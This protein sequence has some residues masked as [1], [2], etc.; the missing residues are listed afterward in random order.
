MQAQENTS[1]DQLDICSLW[2]KDTGY[3]LLDHSLDVARVTEMVC[4]SL[5]FPPAEQKTI[6]RTAKQLAALHDVGK[7]ASGFQ[8]VL[9]GKFK[10]WHRHEILSAAIA[11]QIAPEI[12]SEGLLAIITHH[13]SILPGVVRDKGEKCLPGN[14]L[15][16]FE[17]NLFRQMVSELQPNRTILEELLN[18]LS[19]SLHA[20]WRTDLLDLDSMDL[21][22]L[23]GGWLE[24][25]KGIGQREFISKES[26]RLA[27]VLRGVLITSDHMASAR[28]LQM[29]VPPLP[30]ARSTVQINSHEL[31]DKPPLP[32]QAKCGETTGDVILKAPTGSGKTAAVLLWAAHNQAENGRLFYV[33]PHT[34]SINA[35]HQ[36]LRKI[37]SDE[38]IDRVG[39]LHHKNASYLF[40]L[41]EQEACTKDAAQMSRTVSS[42]ARELYHP[43]RVTTPHQILRAALHGKGWELGLLEFPNAC[44][45]FDEIHVFEPLLMGLTIATA[46]WLKSLCSRVMFASA[47]IPRFM[48][49]ILLEELNI[50][51]P[52]V[53]SP[54]LALSGDKEVC[55]KIRH[56]IEVRAGSLI[57]RLPEVLDEIAD[58][59]ETALIVCN[60][61]ATSQQ[62][63]DI[64]ERR[65][66]NDTM[67]LHSRFNSRDRVRIES[68][69]TSKNPPHILVAT[70]AVEV[71]LDLNY[72]RGYT[73]PAPADALG[74]RLGR[75]N[76]S[77]SRPQ[78]AQVVVFDEPSNGYLYDEKITRKTVALLRD[79]GDL[80][81]QH[82]TGI[83]NEIYGDGYQDEALAY[84]QR[85]LC[86]STINKFDDEIIAGTHRAWVED[87]I[88]NSDGQI[89]VLPIEGID[90]DDN[91]FSIL[92]RFEQYRKDRSYLQAKELLVPI[93]IGQWWKLKNEGT[94]Y[95]KEAL[96]E[97][98]T[99]LT[100]SAKKGLDLSRQ[101]GNIM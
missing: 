76:R 60:H 33:L 84:Y 21:Q 25:L 83:V 28:P 10:R 32:F 77:G 26:R 8:D 22:R 71:S 56:R 45:V 36:R 99:T 11:S 86:N 7:A 75:I 1:E 43:I 16:F 82:L 40:R 27:S 57:D 68:V 78:P 80:T 50:P 41:F 81:E 58:S 4:A 100:Y 74:Q 24:R 85:G 61:V 79:V 12:G 72:G 96:K 38:S 98:C 46:K 6:A 59:D 13:K 29:P 66:G 53:I 20:N 19:Q 44:F 35:M 67:L 94:V 97:W 31:K 87:V 17:P 69:I 39:V 23:E 15:P 73:E 48:E 70:Q 90:E 91:T 37:Y 95:Y 55:N 5:P 9:R 42:L 92:K 14:E 51:A 101:I 18:T 93:R 63:Y 89:E 62:A 47:T 52:N 64:V 3:S 88:E 54:D 2:A 34:A 49:K 30:L 65:F